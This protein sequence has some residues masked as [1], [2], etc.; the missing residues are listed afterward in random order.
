MRRLSESFLR[1]LIDGFLRE[2]NK[3]VIKD[4]DLDL[5]IRD[6]YLNIYY[7]GNSLLKLDE[8]SPERYRVEI[9]PEFT[10]GKTFPDLVNE[11][12]TGDFICQVPSIKERILI[13]G[14]SSLEIEYEQMIIRANN[15]ERRNNTDYFVI[16]RQVAAGKAGRFDLTGV[17]WQSGHR[18][19][20][21]EVPLCLM[22]IKFALNPDIQNLHKQIS[23]Y[24]EAVREKAGSMADE[25]E[26]ILH[27]KIE[28]GHID[29]PD[30]LLKAMKTLTVSKEIEN[31]QFIIILIDYNP[32]SSLL[33]LDKLK[34]LPFLNQLKIFRTGFALWWDRFDQL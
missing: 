6:K 30:Y 18:K 7:K 19:E 23:R 4:A 25:A 11:K 20:K 28:L 1:N 2:L 24:Y 34:G 13:K 8:I 15:Y 22:E 9:H 33:D 14:K 31:F 10:G 12:T 16:D 29:Q 17:Y 5:Q 3:L 26:G 32:R 27:Q 21:Q